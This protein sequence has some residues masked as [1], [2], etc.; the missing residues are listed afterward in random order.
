MAGHSVPTRRIVLFTSA[1]GSSLAPFMVSSLI[2]ALPTIGRDFSADAVWLGWLTTAFFLA[3]ATFL[4]P[5]GRFADIYGVKKIFTA[6]IMIYGFSAFLCALAP[7]ILF[8]IAARFLTGIGAAMIF[9]TSI[10]LLSLVFPEEDRGIAIGI[11]VTAMS[12]GFL[13]GF[14]AGGYLTSS[15]GW[16]GI[17]PWLSLLRSSL[18]SSSGS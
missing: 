6:G 18:L 1:L 13:L 5:L 17:F 10:A 2:V 14:L 7:S 4:V 11:N 8:L 9:G 15:V 12:A 16:R 3:A